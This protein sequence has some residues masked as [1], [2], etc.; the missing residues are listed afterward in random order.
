VSREGA[1]ENSAIKKG[2]GFNLLL[3]ESARKTN[4]TQPPNQVYA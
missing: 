3:L 1:K 2:I 4:W